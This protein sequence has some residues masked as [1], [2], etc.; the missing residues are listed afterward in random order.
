MRTIVS[1][2]HAATDDE[3][4]ELALGIDS[5]LFT[6]PSGAESAPDRAARLAA[7]HDIL[8][9]LRR[10][11]AELADYAETLLAKASADQF[12]SIASRQMTILLGGVPRV[13]KA[14][15]VRMVRQ[16]AA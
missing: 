16:V 7:A 14:G 2:Q 1:G 3:F 11:D 8:Q 9:D 10:E 6:G 4:A 5:E 13:G 15:I 12:V